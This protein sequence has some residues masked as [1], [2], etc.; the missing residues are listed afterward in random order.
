MKVLIVHGYNDLSCP[1]FASRLIVDAIPATAGGRVTLT[2]YPGGH[3]FYSRPDSGAAF[4]KDV[5]A[6]YGAK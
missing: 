6:L 5:M 3:M 4:R 1:F 2:S